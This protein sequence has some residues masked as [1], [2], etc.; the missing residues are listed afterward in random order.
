MRAFM[1]GLTAAL[2]EELTSV[3]GSRYIGHTQLLWREEVPILHNSRATV[4]AA[5]HMS[6]ATAPAQW[7]KLCAGLP[8]Q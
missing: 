6:A 8:G 2:R 3:S 7:H 1:G 4:L 5:P